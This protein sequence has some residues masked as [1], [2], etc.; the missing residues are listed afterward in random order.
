M[1]L[2][3]KQ[4]NDVL[5][6]LAQWDG[7]N[8]K[9]R[10]KLLRWVAEFCDQK[11]WEGCQ[12]LHLTDAM[13]IRI[14]GNAGLLV[15][16]WDEPFFF[17]D[18]RSV[19]VYPDHFV[20]PHR[21]SIGSGLHLE[22]QTTLEGQAWHRGPVIISW[23]DVIEPNR[24]TPHNLVVHEFAHQLDMFNGGNADGMPPLPEAR[25]REWKAVNRAAM[26]QLQYICSTGQYSVLDCYGCEHPAE[27]F[28]VS[29]E[30]FFEAPHQLN[31]EHP[32]LFEQLAMFYRSDPQKWLYA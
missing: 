4:A 22:S 28:A 26:E 14:A 20:A 2:I 23:S 32:E 1:R 21:T 11:Y 16:G 19:L 27:F 12:G 25:E 3:A 30:A 15:L 9:E 18:V 13:K 5:P 7:M 31:E 6:Q 17:P 24:G 10:D 8:F 29:S